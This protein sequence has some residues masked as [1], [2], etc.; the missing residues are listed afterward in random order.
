MDRF[1]TY[2]TRFA[3]PPDVLAKDWNAYPSMH[4]SALEKAVAEGRGNAAMV[5]EIAE[6]KA[7]TSVQRVTPQILGGKPTT[8][9]GRM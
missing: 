3:G 7:G 8:R 2:P 6:R 5:K 4:I 9:V 1:I